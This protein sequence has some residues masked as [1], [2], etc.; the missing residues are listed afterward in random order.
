MHLY[1]IEWIQG[2][3]GR[4]IGDISLYI[5]YSA[6]RLHVVIRD[7]RGIVVITKGSLV[8]TKGL[9]VISKGFTSDFQGVH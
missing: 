7:I 5:P 9:L 3:S 2:D 4:C 8:I 6:P 1:R